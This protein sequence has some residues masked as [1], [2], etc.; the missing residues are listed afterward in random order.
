[1]RKKKATPTKSGCKAGA[2]KL[3]IAVNLSREYGKDDRR[4]PGESGL[5]SFAHLG[6]GGED[7]K[8]AQLGKKE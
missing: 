6:F 8:T 7:K 2:V 1:M 3:E 5:D 4:D